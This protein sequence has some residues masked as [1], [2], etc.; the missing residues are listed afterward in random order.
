MPEKKT[1]LDRIKL[2]TNGRVTTN[3]DW[4]KEGCTWRKILKIVRSADS[5]GMALV[6]MPLAWGVYNTLLGAMKLISD[7]GSSKR[8]R[9]HF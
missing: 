3:L 4:G 9:H 5:G 6:G 2:Q 1:K 8:A 7:A